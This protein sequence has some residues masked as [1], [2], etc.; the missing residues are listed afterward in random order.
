MG[1]HKH[2]K[3]EEG[4]KSRRRYLCSPNWT[5]KELLAV[6]LAS[7]QKRCEKNADALSDVCCFFQLD[8]GGREFYSQRPSRY[9]ICQETFM[10]CVGRAEF[11]FLIS[12]A[13]LNLSACTVEFFR[14]LE[15]MIETRPVIFNMENMPNGWRHNVWHYSPLDE[16]PRIWQSLCCNL[17]FLP[18]YDEWNGEKHYIVSWESKNRSVSQPDLQFYCQS[19]PC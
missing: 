11:E 8:K 4:C 5:P 7:F 17:I 18:Q 13:V 19:F 10:I 6:I 3:T 14:G 12:N 2:V 1:N 9:Y 15:N 16:A